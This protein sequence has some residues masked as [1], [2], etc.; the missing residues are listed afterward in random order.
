[1]EQGIYTEI[2]IIA[3]VSLVVILIVLFA[4]YLYRE[5]KREGISYERAAGII[6]EYIIENYGEKR[7]AKKKFCEDHD[8]NYRTLTRAINT[9]NPMETPKLVAETL[10]KIGYNIELVNRSMYLRKD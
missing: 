8:L 7:G 1:M 4:I 10:K 9:E 2:M 6:N 5:K 3:S